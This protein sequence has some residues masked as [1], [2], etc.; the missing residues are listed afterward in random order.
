[1]VEPAETPVGAP[2]PGG[3]SGPARRGRPG[4]RAAIVGIVAIVAVAGGVALSQGTRPPATSSIAAPSPAV[5]SH[6]PLVAM[7]DRGGSLAIADGKGRVDELAGG[8][9]TTFGFP[10]WSPDGSR[11]AA[12]VNGAGDAS[13]S[14]FAANGGSPGAIA[15]SSPGASAGPASASGSGSVA[16][17][18]VGATPIVVYRSAA[19]PPFYL[20]WTPDSQRVSFLATEPD[21]ISLRVAPADGS[22]PLDGGP[23]TVIRQ[24]SPLYFDWIAADRLVLHVGNGPAGFLGEVGPDGAAAGPTLVGTGDFRPAVSDVNGRFLAYARGADPSGQ[25]VVSARDGSAE[26]VTPVF[27]PAAIVFNPA[28]DTVASIAAVDAGHGGLAFPVGP[29]RLTDAASGSTRTLVDGSVVGFFWSP[30][31]QTIAVLRLQAGGGSTVA[32]GPIVAAAAIASPSRAPSTTPAPDELHLLF[33]NVADGTIHSNRVVQLTNQFVTEF[34][35]YFDQ[36]ALSHRLWAPDGSS[37]LLPLVDASGRS[38]LADLHPDGTP[39]TRT[40]DG[41]VGFWSP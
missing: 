37:F 5:T 28:G 30:D 33:V 11:V 1:M 6:D 36:Y 9:G 20:Y 25:L 8:P 40:F 19:S 7:I 35:P 34:L 14:I 41:E 17:P 4:R 10:A 32:G 13:I 15:G 21:G 38:Q 29:L 3:A 2:D 23:G 31:G 22:A 16:S 27:G 12:I 24:G 39:S 18:G 26:H